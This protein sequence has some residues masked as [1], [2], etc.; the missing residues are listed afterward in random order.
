MLLMLM[1]DP[2]TTVEHCLDLVAATR[3]LG[4]RYRQLN[5]ICGARQKFLTILAIVGE[6]ARDKRVKFSS[7]RRCVR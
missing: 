2:L 7:L 5:G 1:N 6:L 4:V 3:C